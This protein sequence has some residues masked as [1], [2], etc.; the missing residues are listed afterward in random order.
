MPHRRAPAPAHRS[1]PW[2]RCAARLALLLALAAAAAA[3]TPAAAAR[4]PDLLPPSV[5]VDGLGGSELLAQWWSTLLS[6]PAAAN[7]L[8]GAGDP[9]LRLGAQGNVLA[10][11]GSPPVTCTV[12]AGTSMFLVGW[13]TECSDVE[14]PPFF[15]A[16]ARQRQACALAADQAI[17]AIGLVI[18]GG[19]IVDIRRDRFQTFSK[20]QTVQLPA[21]N[22]VG[23]PAQRMH[24]G[25]H[26]WVASLRPLAPGRHTIDHTV[27]G[28]PFPFGG[29]IVV[30][31][32]PRA[33]RGPD[34]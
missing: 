26:A 22:I 11:G 3:P 15:G 20:P 21:D 8:A 17:T 24:F 5:R 16:D 29:T 9:C 4:P 2:R 32:V 6:L 31:V 13:S 12:P 1:A 18:D 23:V 25:A 34:R 7:P 30:N 19:P 33:H 10:I 14:A 27:A 28:A